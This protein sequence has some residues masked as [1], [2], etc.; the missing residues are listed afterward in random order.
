M[1][2]DG[3][4]SNFVSDEAAIAHYRSRCTSLQSQ[5]AAAE[6][7]ILEFTESSKEL[8]A[9]LESEL[10]RMDKAEKGMRRELDETRNE[11]EEWKGKYT[12]ALKDHTTT[13]THMQRELE[14]LRATE[15]SLRTRLRD[16][17]LDND[18]LEKSEREKDS[19]L[20][21]LETRYNKSLERIALLEEELVAKA[22]LEEEVQRLKDEL[23][24]VNEELV[25]TRAQA[26]SAAAAA[27]AAAATA[28]QAAKARPPSSPSPPATL[29]AGEQAGPAAKSVVSPPR[30][31]PSPIS[32]PSASTSSSPSIEVINP[33][34]PTTRTRRTS[35]LISPPTS[36]SPSKIARPPSAAVVPFPSP[37][38]PTGQTPFRA[39][40]GRSTRT[41]HLQSYGLPNSPSSPALASPTARPRLASR[42]GS[43]TSTAG[44][45]IPRTDTATMIRDMQQMT[46]R[47]RMLTQRL[48]QRRSSVMRGSAIPR[49][50]SPSSAN[51][52]GLA[53]GGG[54]GDERSESPI[55]AGMPRSAT[56]RSGLNG[57]VTTTASVRVGAPRPPSRLSERDS[58]RPPS[59]SAVLRASIASSMAARAS[60]SSAATSRPSSRMSIASGTSATSGSSIARPLT[61]SNYGPRSA[62][63]TGGYYNSTTSS[64]NGAAASRNAASSAAMHPPRPGSSL[65]RS[66]LSKSV[67]GSHAHTRTGST[68]LASSRGG[69]TTPSSY[70]RED[71]A[72]AEDLRSTVRGPSSLASNGGTNRR[73]SGVGLGLGSS[74]LGKSMLGRRASLAGSY[75]ARSGGAEH[76]GALADRR[77]ARERGGAEE[78]EVPPVP[79]L[80]ASSRRG[81]AI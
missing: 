42:S 76:S 30:R 48:D 60:S 24:D 25:V 79:P 7:D 64:G 23:R 52:V 75:G 62:T 54:E 72:G 5:L 18:D 15:K 1:A 27:E 12:T 26:E 21:D 57:T 61:P 80:P 2:D 73:A 4:P 77:A 6:Q 45:G 81:Y 56:L 17:E 31:T 33:T 37:P 65:G 49:F 68:S 53:R 44:V 32:P 20:Q 13:I 35:Q 59:R 3:E 71:D 74:T 55:G 39:P 22:Q 29:V 34:P 11:K 36:I 38:P 69:R 41:A 66:T 19:S 40:L 67:A 63:P 14:T 8:Q 51:I 28:A 58:T 70:A 10:E 16:M 9:E 78:E 47:V 46:S 43:S 50:G